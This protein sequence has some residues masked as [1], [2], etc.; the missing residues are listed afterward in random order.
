MYHL[1][2]QKSRRKQFAFLSHIFY[3][4]I[5]M[6]E[7]HSSHFFPVNIHEH[8]LIIYFSSYDSMISF[9]I[10]V[11]TATAAATTT[12]CHMHI[13]PSVV[14]TVSTVRVDIV[15]SVDI[16]GTK[17]STHDSYIILSLVFLHTKIAHALRCMNFSNSVG[18]LFS[19]VVRFR[20]LL[21]RVSSLTF[22]FV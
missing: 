4:N 5:T 17:V 10:A 7:R 12:C 21:S 15:G 19:F 16:Y 2:Y 9:A 8:I 14:F 20:L 6:P 3:L 11:T 22:H 1:D 18:S 13:T